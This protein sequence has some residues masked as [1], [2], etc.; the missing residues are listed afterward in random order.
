[1]GRNKVAS[2]MEDEAVGDMRAMRAKLLK[3]RESLETVDR[4][5]DAI[6][7]T[8]LLNVAAGNFW[9][10][11]K[12]D[13]AV[14]KCREKIFLTKVKGPIT[15]VSPQQSE[16]S[17]LLKTILL[18]STKW[19][20]GTRTLNR[21]RTIRPRPPPLHGCGPPRRSAGS[22]RLP[23]LPRAPP[24]AAPRLHTGC[25]GPMVVSSA[26]NA[27]RADRGK[28]AAGPGRHRRPL[29]KSS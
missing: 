25:Q 17:A 21:F 16:E 27:R 22:I 10:H 24:R 2:F 11:M 20:V 3:Q 8:R 23:R 1:M 28:R 18:F 4:A 7:Q 29:P 13:G 9:K 5:S 6:L 14:L 19:Q 15:K 12:R 26:R